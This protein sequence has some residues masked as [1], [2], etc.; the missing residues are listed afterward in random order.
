MTK[1]MEMIRTGQCPDCR[2]GVHDGRRCLAEVPSAE[3]RE[4]WCITG[5]RPADALADIIKEGIGKVRVARGEDMNLLQTWLE[6]GPEESTAAAVQL[7][8]RAV[9]AGTLSPA[10]Y[11]VVWGELPPVTAAGH[12]WW[13]GLRDH[14]YRECGRWGDL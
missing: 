3:G 2:H 10:A 1:E 7:D 6:G 11:R 14:A 8:R 13:C 12:R 9:D 4:C 5:M